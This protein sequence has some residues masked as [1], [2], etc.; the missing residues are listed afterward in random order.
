MNKYNME[1]DKYNK[2]FVTHRRKNIVFGMSNTGIG[3]P[4]FQNRRIFNTIDEAKKFVKL[5]G[6]VNKM[7]GFNFF[8][9]AEVE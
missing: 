3:T 1:M 5:C 2:M 6:G 8:F 4:S 9:D 7:V